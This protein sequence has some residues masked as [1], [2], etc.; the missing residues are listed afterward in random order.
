MRPIGYQLFSSRHFHPLTDTLRMLSELRYTQVEGYGG[1]FRSGAE[2][3]ELEAALSAFNLKM[4]TV[5]M[6]LN[7]INT[8]PD[9]IVAL[10]ERFEIQKIVIPNFPPGW[11]PENSD[12]WKALGQEITVSARPLRDA[13][14][15]VIYHTHDNEILPLEDGSIAIDHILEADPD[16]QIQFDPAW[17]FKAN[18]NPIHIIETYGDRIGAAHIKDVAKYGHN[19]QEHGWA[20]VGTG[21]MNWDEI[22]QALDNANVNLRVVEHNNPAD[23]WRF[24]RRSM[25]AIRNLDARKFDIH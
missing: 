4:P 3:A 21:I 10:A 5:H 17:A 22:W 23:H 15:D 13:G 20:D 25:E 14:L 7:K 11:R 6:S 12:G 16:L 18:M 1:L 24:A 2:I 9:R 8:V 19:L